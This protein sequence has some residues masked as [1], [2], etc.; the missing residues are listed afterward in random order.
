ML[1]FVASHRSTVL[2]L[3]VFC[4]PTFISHPSHMNDAVRMNQ[5]DH[6]QIHILGLLFMSK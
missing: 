2:F 5:Q 1:D 6:G 4:R 3:N